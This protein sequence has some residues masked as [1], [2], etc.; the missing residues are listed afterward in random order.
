[1]CATFSYCLIGVAHEVGE[2]A[3]HYHEVAH[4]NSLWII[5]LGAI[6]T[7]HLE[8]DE[9]VGRVLALDVLHKELCVAILLYASSMVVVEFLN[10]AHDIVFLLGRVASRK[11]SANLACFEYINSFCRN[12]PCLCLLWNNEFLWFLRFVATIQEWVGGFPD[13]CTTLSSSLEGT[14]I[15]GKRTVDNYEVAYCNCIHLSDFLVVDTIYLICHKVLGRVG[16]FDVLHVELCI[17]IVGNTVCMFVVELFDISHYVILGCSFFFTSQS[18]ANLAR[19]RNSDGFCRD[20]PTCGIRCLCWNNY[21]WFAIVRTVGRTKWWNHHFTCRQACQGNGKN[22]GRKT[23][24]KFH[25]CI[26]FI[27][28]FFKS[29]N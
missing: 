7:I 21:R 27:C 25:F 18:S 16:S 12:I 17:T 4:S 1:M 3:I 26:L 20:V 5:D 9:V 19:F 11:S 6:N 28:Y 23:S 15:V 8:C 2:F 24:C 22:K 13:V 29:A 14:I 10:V